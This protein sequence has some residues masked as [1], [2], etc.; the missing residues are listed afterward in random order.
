MVTPV[1]DQTPW[2]TCWSFATIAASESSIL[3][4]MG[5]TAEEYAQKYGEELDLSEKHLAWFTARALPD[6]D[7]YPEGEYPYDE[8]Q[9]G[10][11]EHPLEGAKATAYD[12]GGNYFLSTS[13]LAS[14]IGV[15]TE[16]EVPYTDSE[17]T[18]SRDGDW[19]LPEEMR[20]AQTF[21]IQDANMLPSV[22]G[23]DES[24]EYVYHPEG[25]EA[26]KSELLKGRAVGF[27]DAS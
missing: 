2:G 12:F 9:A 4:A 17:G 8:S 23:T 25:T 6:V 21:E 26:I 20:F 14:G 10:E 19:T 11:G 13:S 24:G 7:A 5:L 27:C 18:L 16:K 3:S 1:K 22:R 15:V